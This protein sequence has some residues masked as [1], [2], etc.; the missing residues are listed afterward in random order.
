MANCYIFSSR[1]V[2]HPFV[3]LISE[4]EE[5]ESQN[6]YG[7]YNH[8][9]YYSTQTSLCF[10]SQKPVQKKYIGQVTLKYLIG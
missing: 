9:H 7:C 4:Q 6:Y 5:D 10:L 8:G 1:S 2:I 3:L